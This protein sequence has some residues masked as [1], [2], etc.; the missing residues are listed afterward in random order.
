MRESDFWIGGFG[1]ATQVHAV[2]G[3]DPDLWGIPIIH[4][5]MLYPVTDLTTLFCKRES[6]VPPINADMPELPGRPVF[7]ATSLVM[8]LE[9][10]VMIS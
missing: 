5:G 9:F 7:A 6:R 8:P 2:A 4:S 3:N 10:P 1:V